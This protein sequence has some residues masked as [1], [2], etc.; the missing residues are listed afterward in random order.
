MDWSDTR[1]NNW[2]ELS[3]RTFEFAQ[4]AR[5]WFANGDVKTKTQ[6][7]ATLGSN[8]T[9]KDKELVIDGQKSFFLIEKGLQEVREI[10]KALEPAKS[11]DEIIQNGVVEAL[12][13]AWL[14]DRD[15]NPDELVQSQLSYR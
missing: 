1:Q 10:A 14:G 9:I 5:Y 4:Y 7:L 15:S 2:L 6:V 3:E 8:L 13:I 12:R 11:I